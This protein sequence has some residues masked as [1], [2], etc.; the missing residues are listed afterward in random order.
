MFQSVHL[1]FLHYSPFQGVFSE[2]FDTSYNNQCL[3][4]KLDISHLFLSPTWQS[5]PALHHPPTV[6]DP[7]GVAGHL[8]LPPPIASGA[9]TRWTSNWIIPPKNQNRI[10]LKPPP[11]WVLLLYSHHF[12]NMLLLSW[13]IILYHYIMIQYHTA[14]KENHHSPI[15]RTRSTCQESRLNCQF[16][17]VKSYE[18][19]N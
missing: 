13:S 14:D 11:R 5:H 16:L 3:T 9:M 19:A 2:N 1:L 17:L 12:F 18:V 10:Y 15:W 8:A 4:L 7:S 6:G